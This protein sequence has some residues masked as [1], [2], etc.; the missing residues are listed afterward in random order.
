M[1][2]LFITMPH[3]LKDVG[4]GVFLQVVDDHT[5]VPVLK[6][7]LRCRSHGERQTWREARGDAEGL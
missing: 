5:C 1:V 4:Y 6:G 2:Q 7:D 3:A